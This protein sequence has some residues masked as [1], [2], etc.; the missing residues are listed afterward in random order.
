MLEA[1]DMVQPALERFYGSLTDD[2]KE[3]FNRLSR[4]G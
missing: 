2:Q 3:R 1:L 4:Q